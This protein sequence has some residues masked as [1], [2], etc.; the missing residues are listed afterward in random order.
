MAAFSQLQYEEITSSLLQGILYHNGIF[1]TA[2]KQYCD[3]KGDP[4]FL[5]V[6]FCCFFF[7]VSLLWIGRSY[8]FPKLTII[9][10]QFF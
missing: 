10:F 6:F 5:S 7:S 8:I 3:Q 2:M 1:F 9:I 4:E